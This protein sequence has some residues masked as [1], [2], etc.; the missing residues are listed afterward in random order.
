MKYRAR[1]DDGFEFEYG[2][3]GSIVEFTNLGEVYC[4]DTCVREHEK[5]L[6]KLATD[7]N[8]NKIGK[9]YQYNN[10]YTR[11]EWFVAPDIRAYWCSHCE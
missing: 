6:L 2:N 5:Q 1:Y 3:D 7:R 10:R 9:I 4:S 11:K 8:N